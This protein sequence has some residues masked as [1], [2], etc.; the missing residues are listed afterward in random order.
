M[1][2]LLIVLK[3]LR[4]ALTGRNDSSQEV[5]FDENNEIL[6]VYKNSFDH[7]FA[8]LLKDFFNSIIGVFVSVVVIY[9]F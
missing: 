5:D 6:D 1:L 3:N 8:M 9:K 4:A 7:S 2:I